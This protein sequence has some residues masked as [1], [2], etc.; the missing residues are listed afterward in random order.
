[1]PSSSWFSRALLPWYAAHRRE[2]PWRG[3]TDPY[4]IWLC[5]VILQQTRV[6]QGMDYWTRFV[7]RWPTVADLAAATEDEVLRA[8]QGLG[9][10]S[11]ARNLLAAARQVAEGHSGR[12]PETFEG[13][14]GLKGVGDYTAAAMGSIAFGLPEPAVDGNAYR[15]L[16][17]VFGIDAPIDGVPGRKLF[18][19]LAARLVDRARPGDHNQA[20]MELGATVCLPR[21][22]RCGAC[23]LATKCVARATGRIAELPMKAGRTKVRTRH[24]NYLRIEGP[25]G[26][27]LRKRTGKDIW[28]GLYELPLVETPKA[29][30]KAALAVAIER[31]V[32][33]G[34]RIMGRT[35]SVTHALSHQLI[36]AVFWRVRVDGAFTPPD[37]W[38]ALGDGD[39]AR[40]AVPRLIERYLN[41]DGPAERP[42]GKR[43][44]RP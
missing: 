20:V 24:F 29:V 33:H 5:E 39:L 28:Q 41:G 40:F 8:W 19:E 4:R 2:L 42:S 31:L 35:A 13:L 17:R 7:E 25:G 10:Y 32:P 6:D 37:G 12:F 43:Y 23:P 26:P 22:P 34:A 21:N 16:A 30:G 15:V 1:M 3:T 14:R 36:E 38:L 27:F 11:R 9:Y 44:L 18:R